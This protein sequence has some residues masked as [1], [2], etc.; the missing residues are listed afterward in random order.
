MKS[1]HDQAFDLQWLKTWIDCIDTNR[2]FK[3]LYKIIGW[4]GQ[5]TSEEG[6]M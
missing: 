3:L 6:S 5:K 2:D 1:K 4:K